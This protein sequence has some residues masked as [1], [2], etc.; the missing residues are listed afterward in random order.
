METD[1][2]TLKGSAVDS[3]E[4][5]EKIKTILLLGEDGGD[6]RIEIE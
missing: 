6:R 2:I 1:I 5:V 4:R 3:F